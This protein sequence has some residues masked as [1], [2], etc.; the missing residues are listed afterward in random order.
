MFLANN[1][2]SMPILN[3]PRGPA[4]FALMCLGVSYEA[5]HTLYSTMDSLYSFINH[6]RTMTSSSHSLTY[7][8]I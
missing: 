3:D 6:P 2:Y 7:D 5:Q 4:F 8:I 1:S